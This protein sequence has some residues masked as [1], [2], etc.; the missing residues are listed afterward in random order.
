MEDRLHIFERSIKALQ[1][2]QK[3]LTKI[4][5]FEIL[6]SASEEFASISQVE[7]I[8]QK[9]F[10]LCKELKEKMDGFDIDNLDMK[11]IIR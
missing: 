9:I 1:D 6:K 4:E 10:P 3:T 8:K 7:F 2:N 5:D 11:N